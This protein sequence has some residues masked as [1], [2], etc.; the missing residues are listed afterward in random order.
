MN[1]E[2]EE[3][4]GE[5]LSL[6]DARQE[7]ETVYVEHLLCE[8]DGD[9]TRAAELANQAHGAFCDLVVRCGLDADDYKDD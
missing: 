4:T 5:V 1:I 7:F 3:G 9:V 2:I 8:T 6:F